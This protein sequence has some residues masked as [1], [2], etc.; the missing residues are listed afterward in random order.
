MESNAAASI[1]GNAA[2]PH[3]KMIQYYLPLSAD[4]YG[5]TNPDNVYPF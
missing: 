5:K 3:D 2:M 4:N 1:K